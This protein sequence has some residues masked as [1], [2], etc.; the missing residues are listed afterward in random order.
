MLL[1]LLSALIAA[2]PVHASDISYT[3]Q[4]HQAHYGDINDDGIND[5][6]LQGYSAIYTPLHQFPITV[7][8]VNGDGYTDVITPQ[9]TML[10]WWY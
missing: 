3:S 10:V 9:G 4:I 1:C 7:G 6:L 8:D 5:L 2:Q